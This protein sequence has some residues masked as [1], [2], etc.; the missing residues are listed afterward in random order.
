MQYKIPPPR[1]QAGI[2][3]ADSSDHSSPH[4]FTEGSAKAAR[5]QKERSLQLV[6]TRL[7]V[8]LKGGCL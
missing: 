1:N 6:V 5:R 7:L 3:E 4:Q 2:A 8:C